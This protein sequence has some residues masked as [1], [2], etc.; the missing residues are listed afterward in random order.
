MKKLLFILL[1]I[2][3]TVSVTAQTPVERVAYPNKDKD[4]LFVITP[5]FKMFEIIWSD[6]N[7][8]EPKPI[9]VPVA[10]LPVLNRKEENKIKK[11]R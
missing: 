8:T 5:V 10:S 4:T 6:T 3:I 2:T 1:L 11:N 9:I 7:I